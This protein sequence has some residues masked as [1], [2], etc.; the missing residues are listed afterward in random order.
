MKYYKITKRVAYG[1]ELRTLSAQDLQDIINLASGAL[2]DLGML[3]MK[4]EDGTRNT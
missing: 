3:G 2:G 4:H 1:R